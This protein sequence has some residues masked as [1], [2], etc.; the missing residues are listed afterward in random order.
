MRKA[1]TP[2][3]FG[4]DAIAARRSKRSFIFPTFFFLR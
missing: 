3:W 4:D 2:A 1:E